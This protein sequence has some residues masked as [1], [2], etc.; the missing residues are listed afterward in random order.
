MS[1]SQTTVVVAAAG[2]PPQ[3]MAAGAGSPET[4]IVPRMLPG[5]GTWAT[6]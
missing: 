1:S 6:R 2:V 5:L 3:P 4:S